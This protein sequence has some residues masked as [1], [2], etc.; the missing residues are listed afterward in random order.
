M[1]IEE[2]KAEY[3]IVKAK[4]NCSLFIFSVFPCASVAPF[5]IVLTDTHSHR[6]SDE[7]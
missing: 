1:T 2:K 7:Q 3:Q 4:L 5:L 6:V